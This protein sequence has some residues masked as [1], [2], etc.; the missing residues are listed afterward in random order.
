MAGRATF[1]LFVRRLP[2]NRGFLVAAGLD[3]CLEFLE[4]FH[5]T[6][7]EL[8]YLE[9]TGQYGH[10]VLRGL[11]RMRFTGDVW[12]V[13]EGSTLFA[14]EPIIEVSGPIA[15]AQLAETVLLNHVTF[16][17]TVAT[18]LHLPPARDRGPSPAGASAGH[19]PRGG[20]GARGMSLGSRHGDAD[21]HRRG[22]GHLDEAM[23]A[24]QGD[25]CRGGDP[26]R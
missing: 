21:W 15:E 19:N 24:G 14:D 1:S 23:G 2:A 9:R 5:F 11:E 17:T 6:G 18:M 20:A 3:D 12:A 10:D 22:R 13:P 25:A 8:D 7:A 4:G 26:P 16:Q